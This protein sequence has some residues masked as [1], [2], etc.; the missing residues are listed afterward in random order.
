V[1]VTEGSQGVLSND[2]ALI[3]DK[4]ARPSRRVSDDDTSKMFCLPVQSS[5]AMLLLLMLLHWITALSLSLPHRS[6][7]PH[8]T[9]FQPA[10]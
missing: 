5:P 3:P 9:T 7:L 2:P 6:L 10:A 8:M 4:L 1:K